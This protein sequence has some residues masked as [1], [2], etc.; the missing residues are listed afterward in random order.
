MVLIFLLFTYNP[1]NTNLT[2]LGIT[3]YAAYAKYGVRYAIAP[4]KINTIGSIDSLI[5]YIKISYISTWG[6]YIT[7]N[8]STAFVNSYKSYAIYISYDKYVAGDPYGGDTA[9][10]STN[11]TGNISVFSDK[12]DLKAV[13]LECYSQISGQ[14]KDLKNLKKLNICDFWGGN[15]TGSKTD[16]WNQGANVTTFY[17]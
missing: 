1:V 9:D 13:Q 12:Y 11:I 10:T 17:V 14:I 7:G 15:C 6:C 5:P 8:I 2:Y 16:L 4:T 3:K